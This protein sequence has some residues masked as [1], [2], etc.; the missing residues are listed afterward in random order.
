MKNR[1][2]TGGNIG[3][4]AVV[5]AAARRLHAPASVSNAIS[6]TLYSG[7]SF[8]FSRD[9]APV[10]SIGGG[11]YVMVVN[12]PFPRAP[13]RMVGRLQSY[14]CPVPANLIFCI[15]VLSRGGR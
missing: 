8:D 14:A 15:A 9:I 1:T 13:R 11:T 3:T 2:G 4:E 7:L 12:H 6:T 5:K 10:A